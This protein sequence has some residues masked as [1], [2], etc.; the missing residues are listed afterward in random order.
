MSE[1]DA[2]R[3]K[4]ACSIAHGNFLMLRSSTDFHARLLTPQ[5]A[6]KSENFCRLMASQGLNNQHKAAAQAE[7]EESKS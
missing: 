6:L 7:I 1:N 4:A 3:M 5:Q 2:K